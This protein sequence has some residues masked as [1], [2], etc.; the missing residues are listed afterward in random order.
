MP[1][2][3]AVKGD[4]KPEAA[5]DGDKVD[6]ETASLTD[7]PNEVEVK[8]SE[9]I[10]PTTSQ[11]TQGGPSAEFLKRKLAGVEQRLDDYCSNPTAASF[12]QIYTCIYDLCNCRE[13]K[14]AVCRAV[15]ELYRRETELCVQQLLESC[16]RFSDQSCCSRP[17]TTEVLREWR[18]LDRRFHALQV[19]FA[20]LDRYHVPRANLESLA[21]LRQSAVESAALEDHARMMWDSIAVAIQNSCAHISFAHMQEL[22]ET[23]KSLAHIVGMK[24]GSAAFSVGDALREH[25]AATFTEG[26]YPIGRLTQGTATAR[27]LG[28]QRPL[29][30]LTLEFLSEQ[31]LC[32][33]YS[34]QSKQ[35]SA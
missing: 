32:N 31:D 10:T 17:E 1:D 21:V 8:P 35:R 30:R 25:L 12:M 13:H 3:L 16:K 22:V 9:E 6:M 26:Q 33:V 18:R 4:S 2:E 28:T 20:Y 11:A 14:N 5:P 27:V 23:W 24:E 29:A 7:Q 34:V 19:S 15:Y